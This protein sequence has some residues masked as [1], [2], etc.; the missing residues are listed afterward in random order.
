MSNQRLNGW[1]KQKPVFTF[2]NNRK[3]ERGLRKAGLYADLGLAEATGGQF[4]GEI[5]KVNPDYSATDQEKQTTGMHRHHYDFKFNYVLAGEIDI[6][7]DG[8]G[9]TTCKAG[10]TYFIPSSCLLYTSPS[11]RDS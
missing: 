3:F 4:H 10:D 8:E 9:K 6:V 11:P 2:A 5:I 1:N 7:I